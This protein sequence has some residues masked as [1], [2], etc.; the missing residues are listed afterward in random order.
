[1]VH[2]GQLVRMCVLLGP[3]GVTQVTPNHPKSVEF[4]P[5]K[6]GFLLRTTVDNG[7]EE[8]KSTLSYLALSH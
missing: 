2:L 7:L 3:C 6:R 1:M 8:R 5:V 4:F